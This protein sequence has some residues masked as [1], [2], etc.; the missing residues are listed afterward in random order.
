MTNTELIERICL[1]IADLSDIVREQ[2]QIIEQHCLLDEEEG[3]KLNGKR[4]A[5][6]REIDLLC[7]KGM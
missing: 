4:E 1:V 5:V 7:G 2:H 3:K 6:E